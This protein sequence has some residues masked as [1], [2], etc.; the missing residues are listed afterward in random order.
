MWLL[1]ED[2]A[3]AMR[4]ARA[5]GVRPTPEQL[6]ALE[7]RRS[8]LEASGSE[9]PRNFRLAGTTAEIRIEGVLSKRV[10][11]WAM[12]FGGGTTTYQSIISSLAIAKSDPN[13]K[14]VV[15]YIDSPGGTVDGLF[16]TL[17][18][19]ESFKGVKPLS[20]KASRA[21]SA[22]YGIAAAAGKIEATNAAA[23]FGS[24]GVAASYY[25]LDSVVDIT[26]TE[27]PDK[28][29][30]VKTPEGK[31]VVQRELD[32]IH[33]LFA[34]A[35]A[36]GRGTTAKDVSENFGRGA[37]LLAGDAK[38][39]GMIDGVA[40]PALRAVGGSGLAAEATT[41]DSAQE[42]GKQHKMDLRTLK[43]Q[44]PDVYE[45]CVAEGVTKERDRV[46]AHIILGKPI[47][48]DGIDLALT[49]IESGTE[50]TVAQ[51]A[52][53]QAAAM[54]RKDRTTRQQESDAA[55]AAADGA[56][57]PADPEPTTTPGAQKAPN[58]PAAKKSMGEIVAERLKARGGI[59]A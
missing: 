55:A 21:L 10:D 9:P 35:I 16:D 49:A 33:D 28:R 40:K 8:E 7:Q 46:T 22:A 45:Q 48:A 6:T 13:V 15:L 41:H 11:L 1:H 43:A 32:A 17:A 51:M 2:T 24:V 4:E 50:M 56:T 52:R 25:V 23:S 39:R 19:I 29:P 38:K 20:V 27:S 47:G 53:Y 26:N 12:L 36:R 58:Q 54:N 5:L 37:T 18:E 31:A 34:D 44:H 14:S 57:P 42:N 59:G 3:R 30:N